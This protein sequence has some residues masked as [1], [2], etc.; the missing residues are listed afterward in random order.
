MLRE[1][2]NA[3]RG[4]VRAIVHRR[5]LERDLQD[6]L[7]FHLAMRA[8]RLCDAGL[9]EGAAA[10]DAERRFGNV[11]RWRERCRRVWMLEPLER[12]LQDLRYGARMLRLSP[13]FTATV[14]AT[15][16]LGV[17]VT[18]AGLAV[19]DLRRLPVPRPDELVLLHWTTQ[20]SVS[21]ASV[22]NADG[23]EKIAQAPF[24]DCVAPYPLY[25]RL[26]EH[27]RSFSGLAAYSNPVDVQVRHRD[28]TELASAR[29][30]SGS[31]FQVLGI[32]AAHGRA[33]AP[34]D[35]QPGA[36]PV[37]VLGD[38]YWRTRFGADAGVVGRA[39]AVNG[40]AVT[41]VG[42]APP[43]FFGFD[44]THVPAMWLPVHTAPQLDDFG[45]MRLLARMPEPRS[46]LL[47]V[48]GRLRPG[49]SLAAAEAQ[50]PTALRAALGDVP[51]AAYRPEHGPR[52]R[53]ERAAHGVNNLRASYARILGLVRW[54]VALV[55]LVACANVANLLLARAAA[56]RREVGVRIALGAGRGRIVRQMLT[57]GLLLASLGTGFGLV[58]GLA[59]SRVLGGLLVPG[60]EPAAFAW[61]RPSAAVLALAAGLC[62]ATTLLFGL[63]PAWATRR[64]V[65]AD[66]LRVGGAGSKGSV[67]AGLGR[68]I[69]AF[70]VAVALLVLVAAGLLGRSIAAYSSFDP[71]FRTD[72]LLTV[73]T[74]PPLGLAGPPDPFPYAEGIRARLAALP[75]VTSA[76]WATQPL[77]GQSMSMTVVFRGPPEKNDYLQIEWVGVGPRFFETVEIPLLVGRDVRDEDVRPQARRLWINRMLAERLPRDAR[78]V[79]A[80]LRSGMC[81]DCVIVGVVGDAHNSDITRP[82]APTVYMAQANDAQ[83][84]LLRTV[85]PPR[86]L[87][88]VARRAVHEAAPAHLV[89]Y[90]RDEAG[91]LAAATRTQRLLAGVAATLGALVLALAAVG[92]Y[93]VLAYSVTRRTGELAVRMALGAARGDVLRLV[94]REGLGVVGAGAVVGL[95][96]ALWC[97][98][99]VKAFLFQVDP[100]DPVAFAAATVVLLAVAALAAYRPAARA[101]HVDP[102]VALRAE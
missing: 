26:A 22:T 21:W 40:T 20:T 77:L 71:G 54:L 5:R 86:T 34:A 52:V 42:V 16:A 28:V 12:F 7:A 13:S 66:D 55:M 64:V 32:V 53:L 88:D 60:L 80:S 9:D 15:L 41:V 81:Y 45:F 63:V 91:F 4:K 92:I 48:V 83:S 35:D 37:A 44:A 76:S 59:G 36:T 1:A 18:T 75:G 94:L 70:E 98:R 30:A 72:H 78:D 101:T 82:I 10:A 58:L 25:A 49:V 33:L 43:G 61:S 23:C 68:W 8:Q 24:E 14:V 97:V 73:Q 38:R 56:R 93:G 2:L 84:F 100:L 47:A 67:G 65:P 27:A 3:V 74:V 39:I 99:F 29:F 96:A 11:M 46:G 57:E 90:V 69:V 85:I 79:G 87:A 31:Y 95:L 17:G 50:L 62:T 6:E 51:D 89:H 102:L 19:L